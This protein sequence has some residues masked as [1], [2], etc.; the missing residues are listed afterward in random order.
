MC[1][2][3]QDRIKPEDIHDLLA[4]IYENTYKVKDAN[5]KSEFI[6]DKCLELFSKDYEYSIVKNFNGE[7][8]GHYPNKIVLL[9]Y[10]KPDPQVEPAS[11]KDPSLEPNQMESM[12]NVNEQTELFKQA[13]YARCR[14]RFVVPVMMYEGRHICRSATL[15]GG[16]EMYGRSG[17]DFLFQSGEDSSL[18]SGTGQKPYSEMQMFDRYRGQ[19]IKLLKSLSVD[20]IC[21]L[22][23]EKKKVKFGMAITSSEK[24]DKENRYKDFHIMSIPYPGCEFFKAWKDNCYLGEEMKFDWNQGYVDACLDI[25]DI[26]LFSNLDVDWSNYRQ[27]NLIHLTQN[28]LKLLL[29]ILKEGTSGLLVHCIS[30][31][32]RTPMFMALLRL[33]LWADGVI[34]QSLS[35]AEILYLTLAY[36]WYLFG[37]SLSDRV[38]RGEEIL[39]FCFHF[40][41]Y[42]TSDEFTVLTKKPKQEPIRSTSPDGYMAAGNGASGSFDP[43]YHVSNGSFTSL[44]SMDSAPILFINNHGEDEV[45]CNSP[46]SNSYRQRHSS[47]SSGILTMEPAHSLPLSHSSSPLDVPIHGR[48]LR[49]NMTESPSPSC[50]S[51]QVIS[52][53]I[54]GGS[55]GPSSGSQYSSSASSPWLNS[56]EEASESELSPRKE[57]LDIIRRLFNNAYSNKITRKQKFKETSAVSNLFDHFAEKVGIKSFK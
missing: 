14:S 20:Y 13:R 6:T 45:F 4:H 19:D 36:D 28:Y 21:D 43:R 17:I 37:H 51:W 34:H 38:N 27:W 39:Y 8:C 50:G 24:V 40:L 29:H 35:P 56:C 52:L 5:I 42:I 26:S 33:S 32:D 9:E 22:M 10:E 11:I 53:P 1:E 57:K 15:A 7:L 54:T 49:T 25:P 46:N 2:N 18:S 41:Y 47:N 55:S 30:G 12:Y 31:W 44:S 3:L 48:S 16:A 23:V